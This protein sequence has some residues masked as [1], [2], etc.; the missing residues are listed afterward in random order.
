MRS[1]GKC[2][3]QAPEQEENYIRWDKITCLRNECYL[4]D[5]AISSLE[6][7]RDIFL[8]WFVVDGY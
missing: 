7:K 4:I 5:L 2:G 1:L 3:Q 8:F 6:K